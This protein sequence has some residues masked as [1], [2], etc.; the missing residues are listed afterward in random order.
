[1]LVRDTKKRL[2]SF[3]DDFTV[4]EPDTTPIMPSFTPGVMGTML[5]WSSTF[6]LSNSPSTDNSGLLTTIG[7][8]IKNIFAPSQ[9]QGPVMTAPAP[10]KGIFGIPTT[11]ALVGGGVLAVGVLATAVALKKAKRRRSPAPTQ[12]AALADYRRRVRRSRR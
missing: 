8:A 9:P 7:T 10:D 6:T 4:S 11:I 1:M 12:A 3:G 2:G 5:P